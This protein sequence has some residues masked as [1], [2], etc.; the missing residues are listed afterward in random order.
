MDNRR[1]TRATPTKDLPVPGGPCVQDMTDVNEI[2]K[3]NDST[4]Q[5]KRATS[6]PVSHLRI[7]KK[8]TTKVSNN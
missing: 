4:F 7:S 1:R 3:D 8:S 2:F 6:M 5:Y